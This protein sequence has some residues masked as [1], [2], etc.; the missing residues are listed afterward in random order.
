MYNNKPEQIEI[1]WKICWGRYKQGW[2]YNQY[3]HKVPDLCTPEKLKWDYPQNITGQKIWVSCS[4]HRGLFLAANWKTLLKEQSHF[5]S[6][7]PGLSHSLNLLSFLNRT[8]P[9]VESSHHSWDREQLHTSSWLWRRRGCVRG[10]CG[11]ARR[12]GH[13]DW[14]SFAACELFLVRTQW[15]AVGW[16]RTTHFIFISPCTGDT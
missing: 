14:S 12:G 11:A 1:Q 6:I 3:L 5:T 15:I 8:R 2:L 7:E 10:A 13:S 9:P 16:L 4:C